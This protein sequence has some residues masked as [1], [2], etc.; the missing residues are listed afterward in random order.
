[1]AITNVVTIIVYTIVLMIYFAV[2]ICHPN[3]E[4]SCNTK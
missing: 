2:G 4:L 1:M 3:A